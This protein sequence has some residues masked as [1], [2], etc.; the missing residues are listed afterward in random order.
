M[1]IGIHRSILHEQCGLLAN[2][3]QLLTIIE[4]AR[5]QSTSSYIA[6]KLVFEH[7][8]TVFARHGIPI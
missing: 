1:G 4:I 5:L 8:K 3:G 6:R 7:T 2:C